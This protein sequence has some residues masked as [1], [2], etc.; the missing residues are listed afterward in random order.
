[1]HTSFNYPALVYTT[2]QSPTSHSHRIDLVFGIV[3]GSMASYPCNAEVKRQT[4]ATREPLR[5][6]LVI[7]SGTDTGG[8]TRRFQVLA[9]YFCDS[10]AF[11]GP[12]VARTGAIPCGFDLI[13]TCRV[14]LF[15]ALVVRVVK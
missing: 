13:H 4:V 2:T 1:M 6:N 14:G 5:S 9:T 3:T 11:C 7:K 15:W 12:R 10:L 8:M